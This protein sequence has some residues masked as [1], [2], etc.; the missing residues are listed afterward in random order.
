MRA[1]VTTQAD[2][3]SLS[4]FGSCTE[5]IS[6]VAVC[7]LPEIPLLSIRAHTLHEIISTCYMDD[8]EMSAPYL[9]YALPFSKAHVNNRASSAS[10]PF[11]PRP[12][13]AYTFIQRTTRNRSA[14]VD[15]MVIEIALRTKARDTRRVGREDARTRHVVG[16]ETGSL[17]HASRGA[18]TWRVGCPNALLAERSTELHRARAPLSGKMTRGNGKTDWALKFQVRAVRVFGVSVLFSSCTQSAISSIQR[19]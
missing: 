13:L 18:R 16:L 6:A 15:G 12:R 11:H 9:S 10:I 19:V 5:H 14:V 8:G 2:R 7:G 4:G 3:Q 1:L 17:D